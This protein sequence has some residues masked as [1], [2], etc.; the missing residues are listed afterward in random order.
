MIARI[1]QKEGIVSAVPETFEDLWHLS[2]IITE[3]AVVRARSTRKYKPSG[4]STEQRVGVNVSVSAEKVELHKHSNC[5]RITG[6]ITQITPEDIAPL[7]TY[8]TIDVETGTEIKIEKQWKTYELDRIREAVEASR[9]S[10]VTIVLV[11]N[12]N[13]VF[14]SLR[15]Y[16]IEFGLELENRAKKKDKEIETGEFFSEVIKEIEKTDGIIVLGGPG[17]AK[18]NLLKKLRA[19]NPKVAARVKLVSASNAERSGVYEV[20]KSPE[21]AGILEGELA[22]SVLGHIEKFLKSAA[23]GDGLAAYGIK[24]LEQAADAGAISVLIMV[25]TLVREDPKYESLLEKVKNAGGEIRIV[26]TESQFAER[27]RAFGGAIALLR[28]RI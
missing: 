26:P 15:Q 22:H 24:Q 11:D 23:K 27:V 1:S 17:F 2:K 5:L 8:H 25:D 7:G 4:S 14:A 18:E 10:I 16:G 20:L 19:E 3:G 12:E 28:Y 9:R 21:L 6:R 13:A